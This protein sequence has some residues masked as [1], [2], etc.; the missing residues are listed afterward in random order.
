MWYAAHV[1]YGRVRDRLA[2]YAR[3]TGDE[4]LK[5]SEALERLAVKAEAA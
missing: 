1:G 5:P 2:A 3:S 4:S